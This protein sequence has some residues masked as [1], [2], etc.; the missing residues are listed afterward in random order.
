[1][2]RAIYAVLKHSREE[3]LKVENKKDILTKIREKCRSLSINDFITLAH[4]IKFKT[5]GMYGKQ[6]HFNMGT[7]EEVS[8]RV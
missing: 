4:E 5:T 1:M 2:F 7:K 6:V 3:I 8:K